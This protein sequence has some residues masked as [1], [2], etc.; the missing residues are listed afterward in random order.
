MI[1]DVTGGNYVITATNTLEDVR[2]YTASSFYN[3]EQ[4][5]IPIDDL[6]SRTNSLGANIGLTA[7]GIAGATLVLSGTADTANSVYDSIDDIVNR[8]PK[9]LTFPLLVEICNYGSLGDLKLEGI[10]IKGNGSLEI[11]NRN[12]GQALHGDSLSSFIKVTESATGFPFGTELGCVSLSSTPL[13]TAI[14]AAECARHSV[15]CYSAA[16]WNQ[17]VR[18]FGTKHSSTNTNFEE[19]IFWTSGTNDFITGTSHQLSGNVYDATYDVT[20]S[21]DA[22]PLEFNT[23]SQQSL[24]DDNYL[25]PMAVDDIVSPMYAYGNYFTSVKVENCHGAQIQLKNICVDGVSATNAFVYKHDNSIGFDIQNSDV[26]LTSC[27]SVR[28]TDAGFKITNSNVDIEGGIIGYRNYSLDGS[29]STAEL[30]HRPSS[31]FADT[32]IWDIASNGNGF[33]ASRS[34]IKFDETLSLTNVSGTSNLGKHGFM[35]MSNGGNG[36]LFDKCKVIGGVGGHN[37]SQEQ[38][39]GSEDFQTTQLISA[40]NKINGFTI[41]SSQ[42]KYQ[43]ILRSQGNQIHGIY[44]SNSAVGSMGLISE[45][46]GNTGLLLDSSEYVYNI[47]AN[48]YTTSY[49]LD[50]SSWISR[51]GHS[52]NTPAVLLDLNSVQNLTVT[53]SSKFSDNRIN[54]SGRRAG[55]IGGRS[56][57]TEAT[58]NQA[59]FATNGSI[60]DS[61]SVSE[62]EKGTVPLISVTNNSYARL[63]GLAAQGDIYQGSTG[64]NLNPSGSVKGRVLSVT[65]NSKVDLYGTSA[66]NTTIGMSFSISS[67]EHLKPTW[68]RSALYAGQNSKIRISGPTKISNF[69]VAA[70]AEDNSKIEIGPALS[71]LGTPDISL[72]PSDPSGHS[73]VELHST[74]ACLVAN[75]KSTLEMVQCGATIST[76]T[77]SINTV[78]DNL[79][80]DGYHSSSFIQFYPNGFTEEL[81]N[82]TGGKYENQQ[83]GSSVSSIAGWKNR[84][85]PGLDSF[86]S[87]NRHNHNSN[88]TGGMCVRAVGGS[89]VIVDQSN[90]EVRM[91]ASCLSGS[92]Y[93]IDGSGNEG[94]GVYTG[95]ATEVLSSECMGTATHHYAGS[96][97]F[98]WNI[99]DT[100]RILASNIK[101]NTVDPSAAGFH[102]PPGRWGAPSNAHASQPSLGP[103]DYYGDTGAYKVD[104]SK[105][106][107]FYNHGPFRLMA[108]ISSDLMTYSEMIDNDNDGDLLDD[109]AFASLLGGTAIAQINSQGYA[110]PGVAAS[111]IAGSDYRSHSEIEKQRDYNSGTHIYGQPIFGG[112]PGVNADKLNIT[113]DD[114]RYFANSMLEDAE[115]SPIA[116][117]DDSSDNIQ[118]FPNFPIPPIHMEW[119]GYLRNFLDE[120]AGDTFAN[121]KHGANKMVKLCSIFRSNTDPIRGGEGRDGSGDYTFGH[122]VRSLNIFDLNKLV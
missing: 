43:G 67:V 64:K 99:A 91:D 108:G 101:V 102:G 71:D 25:T 5:N 58:R 74:R 11:I 121:A 70:L 30:G 16:S 45:V 28:N 51:A 23:A 81:M 92:Y 34:T 6:E 118:L 66:Y 97:I 111:S 113:G 15:T 112:R 8:I 98:M 90:F 31:G 36:W 53:N 83:F 37:S 87:P 86:S 68:T 72:D 65:D 50:V 22:D 10:T 78:A 95:S 103:L 119:Q 14:A 42:V 44:A 115:I 47:G 110:A 116:D 61:G 2:K 104:L 96:Q 17:N 100:S 21:A 39:A 18:A 106:A 120:S 122:G 114:R 82:D 20:V 57:D 33:E 13:Y 88:S 29:A 93:N 35:M 12:H 32:D 79:D 107:G 85:T 38:G 3:W 27:A 89:N 7:S 117:L 46:N 48:K 109:G 80:R 62:Y 75:N 9:L 49:D 73:L 55:V 24:R 94:D 63:L 56:G 76:G 26:V 54:N 4:D 77:S 52:E 1:N 40:F 41:D 60:V 59:M 84:N 69:G 105:A 19:P